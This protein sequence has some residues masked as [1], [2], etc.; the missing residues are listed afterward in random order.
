MLQA[1]CTLPVLCFF[2][3]QTAVLLWWMRQPDKYAGANLLHDAIV[4]AN[5]SCV[6]FAMW[7]PTEQA[8]LELY[9]AYLVAQERLLA[10]T[11]SAGGIDGGLAAVALA[12]CNA[13][14]CNAAQRDW[15]QVGNLSASMQYHLLIQPSSFVVNQSS[16]AANQQVFYMLQAFTTPGEPR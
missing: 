4:V 7:S 1:A 12:H 14:D 16:S 10:V 8:T 3:L 13:A 11:T 5:A 6:F 9:N 2:G 15:M